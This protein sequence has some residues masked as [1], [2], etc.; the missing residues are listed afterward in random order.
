MPAD[1]GLHLLLIAAASVILG[2]VL[3][4][5]S[6]MG[7]GLVVSPTLVL[8]LGPVTGVLLTNLTT[9]VS[10][11][12]IAVT[13]RRD[14]DWRRYRGLAPLIVVG[15]VLGALLVGAVDRN[16]LEVVIG[17]VLLATLA[18]TALV[19]IPPVSGRLPAAVAGTAGG[20]LNTAV[21]VASPAMLVYAQATNWGQRSFAATLQPIFLTMGAVSVVSKVGLGAAPISDLPPLIVIALVLAMVPVGIALGGP[22][23]RRVNAGTGRTIAVVV[24]TAG[25]LTTLAR[26]LAHVTGVF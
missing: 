12:L 20:F 24:V 9:V 23:S 25:A 22:I 5:V 18:T 17:A 6:G 11:A 7:V 2:S 26:G 3:Q 13:L 4:R 16:W 19:H 10:A 14:I 21:G 8:L 15:S 1:F